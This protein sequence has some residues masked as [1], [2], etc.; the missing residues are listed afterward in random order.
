MKRFKKVAF[1]CLVIGFVLIGLEAIYCM[2]ARSVIEYS[3]IR[4]EGPMVIIDYRGHEYIHV[5]GPDG[6]TRVPEGHKTVICE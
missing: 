5:I 2:G 6:V 3:T 1:V 4:V